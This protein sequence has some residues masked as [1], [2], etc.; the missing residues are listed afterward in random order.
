MS[1]SVLVQTVLLSCSPPAQS[2]VSTLST[3]VCRAAVTTA[4]P[5]P[6][7]S[8]SGHSGAHNGNCV[9]AC[10]CAC[11]CVRVHVCVR[12]DCCVHTILVSLC[13]CYLKLCTH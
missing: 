3:V 2:S 13:G 7:Q 6:W 9:C 10:V 4:H 8:S 12:G 11:V 5:L 1:G